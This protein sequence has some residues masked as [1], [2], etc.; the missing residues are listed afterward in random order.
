[1][2]DAEDISE[3]DILILKQAWIELQNKL[4]NQIDYVSFWQ[5]GFMSTGYAQIDCIMLNQNNDIFSYF[6]KIISQ[7]MRRP[8]NKAKSQNH[9]PYVNTDPLLNKADR[10][11]VRDKYAE[12]ARGDT[13]KKNSKTKSPEPL[14]Y[15]DSESNSM[16]EGEQKGPTF[17]SNYDKLIAKLVNEKRL[18]SL[19]TAGTVISC[20]ARLYRLSAEVKHKELN[21]IKKIRCEMIAKDCNSSWDNLVEILAKQ[22]PS[23]QERL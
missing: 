17:P 2:L 21:V 11:V 4:S 22:L 7:G 19:D 16:P 18:P 9:T 12:I 1:M 23:N 15:W 14:H 6:E 8:F 20:L 13:K 5:Y 10:P 3:S